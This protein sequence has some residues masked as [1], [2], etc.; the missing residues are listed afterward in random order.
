MLDLSKTEVVATG[1]IRIPRDIYKI[2]C[3]EGEFKKSY[4]KK[5]PII[6]LT[7]EIFH[8][9]K[10]KIGGLEVTIAGVRC[11][12]SFFLTDKAIGRLVQ[13]HNLMGI[14]NDVILDTDSEEFMR[15]FIKDNYI[16]LQAEAILSSSEY[17]QKREIIQEDGSIVEENLL[18]SDGK[19]VVSYTVEVDQFRKWL[20][21]TEVL[22]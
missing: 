11:R 9:E 8:P 12:N 3:I 20:G 22:F 1:N 5:T 16:G 2:T 14:P 10:T 7:W 13:F 18:D 15:Q 17:I 21:K 6:T 4:T 19:L